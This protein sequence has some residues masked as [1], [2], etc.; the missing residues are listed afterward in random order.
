MWS[1]RISRRTTTAGLERD[2][3]RPVLE[4]RCQL[5]QTA[6]KFSCGRGCWDNG[7][8][9]FD[10]CALPGT[11]TMRERKILLP[12]FVITSTLEPAGPVRSTK[13]SFSESWRPSLLLYQLWTES[14]LTSEALVALFDRPFLDLAPVDALDN[15]ALSPYHHVSVQHTFINIHKQG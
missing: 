9:R 6:E 11:A 13:R 1:W 5:A 12:F 3:F 15:V 4:T 2:F 14:F 10:P 7:A 8:S